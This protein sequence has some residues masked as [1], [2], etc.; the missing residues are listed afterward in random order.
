MKKLIGIMAV[1]LILLGLAG[2]AIASPW[3]ANDVILVFYTPGSTNEY[4]MDI[5]Q[6]SGLENNTAYETTAI[7]N[8]ANIFGST[9]AGTSYASLDVA[10]FL[11]TSGT[12]ITIGASATAAAPLQQAAI[13]GKEGLMLQVESNGYASSSATKIQT[14]SPWINSLPQGNTKSYVTEMNGG[15]GEVYQGTFSQFL[16]TNVEANLGALATGGLVDLYLYNFTTSDGWVSGTPTAGSLDLNTNNTIFELQIGTN[17]V[18]IEQVPQAPVPI[19]PS[20]LL[21]APGL[22]GL[23]GLRRRSAR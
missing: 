22:L 8:S 20:M 19:P 13:S 3:A 9:A 18:E 12:N 15:S 11:Y 4:A 1:G 7:A 10:A 14:S 16:T 23:V 2:Q 17:G 5:G 6:L 21:L